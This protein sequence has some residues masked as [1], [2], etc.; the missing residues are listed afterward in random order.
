AALEVPDVVI[1]QVLDEPLGHRRAAEEVVADEPA[2]LGLERLVVTVEGLVHDAYELAGA[3]GVEQGVP[4]AAPQHL[5]DVPS[6]AGEGRLE[7]LD[8][9]A[10]AADRT[11]EALEVAVDDVGEVVQ[12]LVRGQLQGSARFGF[13][14]LT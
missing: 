13:V 10:V 12:S 9:L 11:V 8:D 14:H 5:D 2:G 4:F 7:L 3:V 6:G 1:A